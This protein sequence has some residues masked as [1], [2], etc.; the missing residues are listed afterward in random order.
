MIEELKPYI[1]KFNKNVTIKPK[2][3]PLDCTIKNKNQWLIIIITYD[4]CIFFAIDN[5]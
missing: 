5:I 3:Y 1:V 4:K 2:I